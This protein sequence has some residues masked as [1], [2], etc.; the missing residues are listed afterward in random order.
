MIRTIMTELTNKKL[1]GSEVAYAL[2]M[3]LDAVGA[4]IS[5][6]LETRCG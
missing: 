3:L 6:A 1:V 4:F 2:M 5:E